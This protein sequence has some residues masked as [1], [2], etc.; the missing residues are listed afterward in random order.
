MVAK[1]LKKA[2]IG[3]FYILR[4]GGIWPVADGVI[5]GLIRV[6]ASLLRGQSHPLYST[7]TD[8]NLA[9]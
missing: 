2:R 5:E 9:C 8:N 7:Q 1:K 6:T 4:Q 3:Q